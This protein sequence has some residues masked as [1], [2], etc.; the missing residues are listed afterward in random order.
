MWAI[1][2]ENNLKN[3]KE[4][5]WRCMQSCSAASKGLSK[6][7]TVYSSDVR[8]AKPKKGLCVPPIE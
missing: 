7:F 3:E 1:F 6:L 8:I 5:L 2:V 4:Y